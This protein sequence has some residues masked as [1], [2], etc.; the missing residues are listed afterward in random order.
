MK[1]KSRSIV[2]SLIALAISL[3][4][5]SQPALAAPDW[6]QMDLRNS[7]EAIE[8]EL[9]RSLVDD[10]PDLNSF[11]NA[12]R[13]AL[14][15]S[16][17]GQ[18]PKLTQ[19]LSLSPQD[20]ADLREGRRTLNQSEIQKI[21]EYADIEFQRSSKVLQEKL[22]ELK[23]PIS[24]PAKFAV[25]G[26]KALVAVN[27]IYLASLAHIASGLPQ[28]SDTVAALNTLAMFSAMYLVS[29]TIRMPSILTKHYEKLE[30][31]KA[32]RARAERTHQI[33]PEMKRLWF[34]TRELQNQVSAE[35]KIRTGAQCESL[36]R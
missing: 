20:F 2:S 21:R 15:F 10:Y 17:I 26:A 25:Q 27:T 5:Y 3:S 31:V 4:G 34:L 1:L 24:V 18:E 11:T 14:F 35:E 19:S 32:A 29:I 23:I 9:D 30:A 8:R 36:F 12:Q 13:S 7:Q 33:T 28:Q 16:F 6:T 22:K